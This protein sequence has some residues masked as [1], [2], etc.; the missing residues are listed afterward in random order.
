[1]KQLLAAMAM[2]SVFSVANADTVKIDGSSTVF[3]ITEGVAEDF[4]K[5]TITKSQLASLGLVEVLRNSA[6]AKPIYPTPVV[7]SH[8]KR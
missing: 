1:M 6:E 8:R 2:L 7:L 3:P 5:E 4:Q